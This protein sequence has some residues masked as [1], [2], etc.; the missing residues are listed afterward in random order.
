MSYQEFAYPKPG[1]NN[2]K[3]YSILSLDGGGTWA[4]IQVKI[5]QQRYGAKAKGHD[6]LKNYDLVIANSGGSM[7]LGALCINKSLD[8]IEILFSSPDVL[9]TI[10]VRKIGPYMA[11]F[12][13]TEKINGLRVQFGDLGEK[14]LTEFPA[15]IGKNTLQI[16]IVAF[17][18]D[19]ERAVYFRSNS[20]SKLESSY[21]EKKTIGST[22]EEFRTVSLV[23]AVH[24]SS[25]APV[26]FFD[27]PAEFSYIYPGNPNKETK[28]RR[29]W[30]GAIGGN[31][32]PVDVGVIEAIANGAEK[33]KIR[34]ASIGTAMTVLPVLYLDNGEP[35]AEFDWLVKKSK[36]EGVVDELEKLAKSIVSDPPDSA[37]FIAHQI[38]GLDFIQKDKRLIRM[39]PLVKPFFN[40]GSKSWVKPGNNWDD[41]ELKSLFEMDMAV[42]DKKD[43]D[44]II[45]MT[46]E[47]FKGYFTNQGIRIGGKYFNS[48]LGH[49]KFKDALEDWKNWK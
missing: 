41:M 1:D 15:Y 27:A 7:V 20:N 44:L 29:F 12:K 25:T 18:Y 11:P 8:E 31:N 13:T 35:T 49:K 32:N 45:R 39:N 2:N 48:I 16:I 22:N 36:N 4:L 38:L 37:T 23:N 34:V 9:K 30:D 47:Y 43:I 33:T 28:K 26:Q 21:I 14:P 24:A 46:D 10:F 42:T 3:P 6:V 5:L 40:S 17:D 19:R